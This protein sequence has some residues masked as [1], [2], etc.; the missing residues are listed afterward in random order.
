VTLEEAFTNKKASAGSIFPGKKKE[1]VWDLIY[2]VAVWY[3]KN[4]P[5]DDPFP[6]LPFARSQIS[7]FLDDNDN[8]TP[9]NTKHKQRLV[10]CINASMVLVEAL[11]ARPLMNQVMPTVTQY[12]GGKSP[13]YIRHKLLKWSKVCDWLCLDF[14]KYDSTIP[15]WIIKAAFDLIK[16]LFDES[17][18]KTIDWICYHFIH[19]KLYMP[20]G[21]IVQK[22][23][24]IPSGSY[25]TQ[26]IGSLVN[27]LM[28]RTW[29]YSQF[30]G[31]PNIY[32]LIE[33]E[34]SY[35][36]MGDD[37]ILFVR[38]TINRKELA[39][40]V[41]HNFG[42]IIHD[43]KCDFG[44]RLENPVFLKRTWT[45]QGEWRNPLELYINMCTPEHFRDYKDYDPIHILYGYYLAYKCAIEDVFDILWIKIELK[46]HGGAMRM[47]EI[48]DSAL[49][50]SL[51]WIKLTNYA[52]FLSI[53]NQM[54]REEPNLAIG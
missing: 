31:K 3:Y 37:N 35:M 5:K 19:T 51:F 4:L 16:E 53:I 13:D 12:A 49:P 46:K 44:K 38:E 41:Y 54:E 25:F 23:K 20:D 45:P 14:S 33:D 42:V 47:L 9:E 48:P 18:H 28:I 7:G 29:Q 26:I 27:M 8:L 36:V 32:T 17:E 15:K 2:E 10:W 24:G 40:Y 6:A 43:E 21:T 52:M 11:Y 30:K 22:C 39:S 1:E 34:L 50:G